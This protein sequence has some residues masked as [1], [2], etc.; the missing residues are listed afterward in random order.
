MDQG[1][2]ES[3]VGLRPDRHPL[4]GTGPRHRQVR[5]DLH[6][7]VAARARL[8]MPRHGAGTAGGFDIRA[9]R[10]HIARRRRIAGNRKGTVPELAVEMLGMYALD[11]LSGT[12]TVVDRS[13]GGE[14]GRKGAHVHGRRAAMAER[15]RQAR[16]SG[17]IEH[18]LGTRGLQLVGQHVQCLVPGNR[19]E[20]GILVAPLLRI[21]PLHRRQD[22]IRV[23]GLL[24]QAVGLDANPALGR[25]HVLRREI[26]FHLGRHAIDHLDGHEIGTGNAV[27]AIGRDVLDGL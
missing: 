12:E 15:G 18:A 6:P 24:H 9:Q 8:G 19:H 13:P 1:E 5:L 25:M 23:V 16:D 2:H 10:N 14:E 7:L 17:F 4:R 11:A 22:P 3:R 20:A 26:R 21:G 27:V